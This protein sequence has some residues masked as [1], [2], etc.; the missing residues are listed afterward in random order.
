[1]ELIQCTIENLPLLA[2]MNK[3]LFE[4][5][6]N[7]NIPSIDVLQ[8]RLRK[9]IDEGI[10]AF[11]FVDMRETVGYALVKTNVIPYYLSHFFICREVRRKHFGT[12]AFNALMDELKCDSID[13]DVFCWNKRGQE[14]WKSLG[15]EERC[16]I[17]R[18]KR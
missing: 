18:K 13:L 5:E 17:M 10:K 1:M 16:I 12:V 9:S 11:L 15:F 2:Q 6:N 8:E 14:F 4:D 3:Q 7:D